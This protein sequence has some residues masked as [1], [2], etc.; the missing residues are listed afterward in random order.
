[1]TTWAWTAVAPADS[2]ARL[3]VVSPWNPGG[4]VKLRPA[5]AAFSADR[6]PLYCSDAGAVARADQAGSARERQRPGRDRER[7][8]PRRVERPGIRVLQRD[9]IARCGREDQRL[10][11]NQ[12]EQPASAPRGW[13]AQAPR[14]R[15][16][17]PR[18]GG[19]G[20]DH[21]QPGRRCERDV[22]DRLALAVGR[23]LQRAEVV[24]GLPRTVGRIAGAGEDVDA[25]G[26]VGRAAAQ[27]A[28]EP[29]VGRGDDDREVL[30]VVGSLAGCT[31]VVGDPIVTEVDGLA[32]AVDPGGEIAVRSRQRAVVVVGCQVMGRQAL[33]V[34]EG[35]VGLQARLRAGSAPWSYPG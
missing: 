13:P 19:R 20:R 6:G 10:T 2:A 7:Q 28:L 5:S 8:V 14:P 3:S 32:A 16:C 9:A 17:C 11:G 18:V 4:G 23:H 15:R 30:E 31:G 33:S 27:P 34:V 35:I 26:R 1:M 25:E 12:R 22:E 21:R 24:L 29:A